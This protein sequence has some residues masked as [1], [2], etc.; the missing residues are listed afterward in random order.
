MIKIDLDEDGSG[1]YVVEENGDIHYMKHG[2]MR[3]TSSWF[4][5]ISQVSRDRKSYWNERFMRLYEQQLRNHPV[6]VF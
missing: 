4:Q 5:S 2:F 1:Y 6:N 3:M